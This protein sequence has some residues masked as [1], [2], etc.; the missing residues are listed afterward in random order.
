VGLG[1]GEGRGAKRR[2]VKERDE[3]RWG[4]RIS[5]RKSKEG[6]GREEEVFCWFLIPNSRFPVFHY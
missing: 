6:G 4:A 2:G 5:K 3:A 1:E